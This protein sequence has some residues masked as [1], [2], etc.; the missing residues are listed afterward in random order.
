MKHL[1]TLI[2]SLLLST[3]L[4][5]RHTVQR[6]TMRDNW[7]ISLNVGSSGPTTHRSYFGHTVPHAA[8]RL[9]RGITPSYALGMQIQTLFNEAPGSVPTSLFVNTTYLSL[10]HIV[11]L[12]NWFCGYDGRPD[13]FEIIA[14]AGLGWGHD[15]HSRPFDYHATNYL[16][17]HF[18]VQFCV[19]LGRQ[20]AWQL[21]L[22][23]TL[24]YRMS[25]ASSGFQPYFN[26]NQSHIGLRAGVT[27]RFRCSHS[28]H[29][30]VKARLYD[31]V[32]I[33]VLNARIND[34]QEEVRR[35][36]QK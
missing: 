10:D 6:S 2:L 36:R 20:R 26:V 34:L 35:L 23:P 31:Q 25:G 21:H 4:Y 8:I 1:Y 3:V 24:T 17:S 18:E 27:Y 29:Y 15:F 19:N 9:S 13:I 22:S 16:T 32:E 30:F 12:N 7:F 14:I 5:A 33:D 28:A 11:N